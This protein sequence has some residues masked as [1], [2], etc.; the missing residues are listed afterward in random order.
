MTRPPLPGLARQRHATSD[1]QGQQALEVEKRPMTA[2]IRA[3]L[4]NRWFVAP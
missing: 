4:S 2:F 1:G 3:A